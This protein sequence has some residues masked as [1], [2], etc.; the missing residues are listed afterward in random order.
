MPSQ[1]QTLSEIRTKKSRF[2]NLLTCVTQPMLKFGEFCV[3]NRTL[4]SLNF[5]HFPILDVP[6]LEIYSSYC[7]LF[8]WLLP[9]LNLTRIFMRV[10]R[11]NSGQK[12]L[13]CA[14]SP[15]APHISQTWSRRTGQIRRLVDGFRRTWL[16]TN[17]LGR[18]QK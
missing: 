13:V 12:Y 6:F 7:V 2:R 8:I 5:R 1:F 16:Q 15:V 3:W 4:K 11:H 14:S 18:L 9:L 10:S 17:K